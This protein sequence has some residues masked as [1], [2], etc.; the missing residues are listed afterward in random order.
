M[1]MKHVRC[2]WTWPFGHR[3]V[4]TVRNEATFLV[5]TRCGKEADADKTR[6]WIIGGGSPLSL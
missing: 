6:W 1:N 5:C 3:W 2:L 4:K